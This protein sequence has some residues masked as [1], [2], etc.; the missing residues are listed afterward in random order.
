MK[1][2]LLTAFEDFITGNGIWILIGCLAFALIVSIVFLYLNIQKEKKEQENN[3]QE[4]IAKLAEK[5]A[6]ENEIAKQQADEEKQVKKAPAKTAA[7]K[8]TKKAATKKPETKKA[9]EP[10]TE[11]EEDGAAGGDYDISFD[12][13]AKE[14]VVKRTNLT[15]ATKRTKTKQQAI[16]YSKPLAEKHGVKLIIH[17]KNE[18]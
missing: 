8:T 18:Q 10:K 7:A 16:D 6:L 5:Y 12:A 2:F 4:L 9:P 13:K 3:K 15:R 1:N 11:P 17:T 14:W